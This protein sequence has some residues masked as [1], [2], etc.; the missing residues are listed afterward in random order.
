MLFVQNKLGNRSLIKA[1]LKAHMLLLAR[2]PRTLYHKFIK[3]QQAIWRHINI[4]HNQAITEKAH[5]TFK[6]MIQ[7]Q[8][9]GDN[10]PIAQLQKA[11]LTLNFHN[12][13][14]DF[15]TPTKE[16]HFKPH[17]PPKT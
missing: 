5:S 16:T 4:G 3:L 17:S 10:V 11:S 13:N 6:H 9:G 7:K 2:P 8:K 12:L 14:S 1:L 15:E